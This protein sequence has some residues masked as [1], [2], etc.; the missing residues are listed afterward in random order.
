MLV[1]AG[2][3][4]LPDVVRMRLRRPMF[5][6][7]ANELTVICDAV[8]Q[9]G[10]LYKSLT[11]VVRNGVCVGLKANPAPT[12]YTDRIIGFTSTIANGY[13]A[14][15]AAFMGVNGPANQHRALETALRDAGL[16]PAGDV[17]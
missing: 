9:G 14:A 17:Q 13:T 8:G 7:D 1:L 11:I 5:D 10:T 15:R 12:S 6:D 2:R 16:L 3:I 4:P